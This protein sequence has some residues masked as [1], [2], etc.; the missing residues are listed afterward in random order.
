MPW[1]AVP[2]NGL[3]RVGIGQ[4]RPDRLRLDRG[5]RAVG[6][7]DPAPLPAPLV[8]GPRE[9][10]DAPVL[11]AGRVP[12]EALAEPAVQLPHLDRREVV[13]EA[14]IE[15]LTGAGDGPQVRL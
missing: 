11:T 12:A 14:P 6:P 7:D 5:P 3:R 2:R 9:A 4:G 8:E 15:V 13:G 10:H 1:S